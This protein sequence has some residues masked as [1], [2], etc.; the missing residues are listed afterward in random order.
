MTPIEDILSRALLVRE[1]ALPADTVTP[2]PTTPARPDTPTDTTPNTAAADL[3]ALCETLVSHTPP[4]AVARFLTDQVPE[5][6]SA[7]VLACVL[8]LQDTCEGA[9]FWWQFAAGAGEPAAAYCLYLHHLARGEDDAAHWWHRQTDDVQP[10]PPPPAPDPDD[11]GL[12]LPWH[13]D[14][15]LTASSSTTTILRLL[16]HVSRQTV[17]PRT[18]AV[19][20]LMAY[21]PSAVTA[22]YLREPE[23]ELPVPGDEFAHHITRLLV[24]T[25]SDV[26]GT[27]TDGTESREAGP[28]TDPSSEQT[29]GPGPGPRSETTRRAARTGP[30]RTER[31]EYSCDDPL[32]P[33]VL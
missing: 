1:R 23:A 22:G 13:G 7:L 21:I 18:A 24:G 5:P 28:V 31:L 33:Y 6:R 11:P 3:E 15:R 14:H 4:A 19:A 25:A 10:P 30:G 29:T 20:S 26:S 17:R 2:A 27:L 16:R 8:Q 12:A 9:R 32:R